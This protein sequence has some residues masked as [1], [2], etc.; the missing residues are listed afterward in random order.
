LAQAL[1]ENAKY[2]GIIHIGVVVVVFDLPGD[3]HILEFLHQIYS[4]VGGI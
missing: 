1:E 4:T 3:D 2:G